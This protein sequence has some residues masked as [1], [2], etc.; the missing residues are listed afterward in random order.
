M[1]MYPAKN[2]TAKDTIALTVNES[3]DRLCGSLAYRLW[4]KDA[5]IGSLEGKWHN[6]TLVAL[7]RFQSEGMESFREVR[8][9]RN[10]NKLTEG[11]GPILMK[12]DTAVYENPGALTFDET[13][14]L[15]TQVP[16][17]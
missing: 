3:N 17:K 11:H 12:G 4:Q 8:F 1:C 16:C 2:V 15:L 10:A 6:D 5:N 7:Y 13:S 14:I 9:L